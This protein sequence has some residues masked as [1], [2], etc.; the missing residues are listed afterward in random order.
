MRPQREEKDNREMERVERV[1]VCRRKLCGQGRASEAREGGKDVSTSKRTKR[2]DRD[3]ANKKKNS[4]APPLR[5][6]PQRTPAHARP[7]NPIHLLLTPTD[8]PRGLRIHIID[9][10]QS[11]GIVTRGAEVRRGERVPQV[12]RARVKEVELLGQNEAVARGVD[13]SVGPGLCL[14]VD[15]RDGIGGKKGR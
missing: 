1:E 9:H 4:L 11:T 2:P 5:R 10:A 7:T 6:R 12:Q 13:L 15:E 3:R 14:C 8:H